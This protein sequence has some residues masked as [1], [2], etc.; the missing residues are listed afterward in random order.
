MNGREGFSDEAAMD[1]RNVFKAVLPAGLRGP[2]K[3]DR[4]LKTDSTTD[5]EPNGQ[6]AGGQDQKHEPMTDEQFE[7]A[8]EHLKSLQSVQDLGAS[9][10]VQKSGPQRFVVLKDG[11]G[12]VIR[13]ITEQELWSLRS[14]KD[15]EKGQLISRSA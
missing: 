15:G 8:V 2:E 13:R 14:T 4:G 12:K 6:M 1:V 7:Q 3:V 9:V 10:E 11:A 5:R